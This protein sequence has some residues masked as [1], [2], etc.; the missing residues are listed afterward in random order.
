MCFAGQ[1]SPARLLM[2]H[3]KNVTQVHTQTPLPLNLL[4]NATLSC[5]VRNQNCWLQHKKHRCKHARDPL[6]ACEK[7]DGFHVHVILLYVH[8]LK[9]QM[10]KEKNVYS[11]DW[12]HDISRAVAW[13]TSFL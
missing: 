11:N 1:T 7:P 10:S 13:L 9:A 4:L 3:T 5:F 12:K 2:Y 8:R 6:N